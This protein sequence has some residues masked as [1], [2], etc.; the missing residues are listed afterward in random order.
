MND[1]IIYSV[2]FLAQ[3]LFGSRMIVQW[4]QSEKAKRVVSP[5]VFWKA[6]L[7]ASG[8][9]LFYGLLRND[10]VIIFGQLLAYFI[11]IRNLQL[12]G[13]WKKMIPFLRWS[14]IF[15]PAF[16][17][18]GVLNVPVLKVEL[19]SRDQLHQPLFMAGA[20]GQLLLN[21]RFV[22]Q[23]YFA[24]K[25]GLPELPLGFW[26]ISFFGSI[27]VIVYA[28]YRLDPVLLLAQVL[29]ITVYTRNIILMRH[30]HPTPHVH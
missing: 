25:S 17:L 13:E 6:S 28:V 14:F 1:Y 8:L 23:W 10:M 19:W 15:F 26:V 9:F 30:S 18:I 29:G 12:D 22:Y 7:F 3:I 2:G 27:L 20:I 11:Y 5:T 4:I 16:I 21:F 24:E